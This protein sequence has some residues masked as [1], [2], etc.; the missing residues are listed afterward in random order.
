MGSGA[1]LKNKTIV[2][3]ALA[4]EIPLALAAFAKSIEQSALDPDINQSLEMT[5]YFC[6]YDKEKAEE[7]LIDMLDK[8]KKKIRMSAFGLTSNDVVDSLIAAKK[9]GCDVKIVMDHLQAAGHTQAAQVVRMKHAGIDIAIGTSPEY[10]QLIHAKFCV[11][12]GLHVEDGSLNYS[13]SGFHQF[14]TVDFTDSK[15][16]AKLFEAHWQ[17]LFDYVKAN[18]KTASK[19]VKVEN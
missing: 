16:R 6:P 7:R 15:D 1:K 19:K 12:D 18:P 10:G 5:T 17:E 4:I 9:R 8:A 14:N 13:P 2:A 11:V 3:I